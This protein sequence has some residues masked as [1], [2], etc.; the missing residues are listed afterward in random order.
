[1]PRTIGKIISDVNDICP[2][3]F[4]PAWKA[5]QL[6]LLDGD[7][8]NNVLLAEFA[9]NFE[10]DWP[11]CADWYPLVFAPYDSIYDYWLQAQIE[12]G[13]GEYEKYNNTSAIFNADF[14]RFKTWFLNKYHPAQGYFI[15][16]RDYRS[17]YV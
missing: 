15:Y 12:R 3:A 4:A 6:A 9:G 5:R 17:F 2:N 8:W 10:Y 16:E 11:E 13:N 14:T 1:M 7:V